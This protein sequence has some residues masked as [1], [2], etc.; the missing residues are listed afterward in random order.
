[1]RL[2][3]QD[4]TAGKKKFTFKGGVIPAGSSIEL[5]VVCILEK[6]Y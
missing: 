6:H 4:F 5:V 3:T 1:M 2:K